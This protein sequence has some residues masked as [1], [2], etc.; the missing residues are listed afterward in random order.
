VGHRGSYPSSGLLHGCISRPEV[1]YVSDSAMTF[2][3]SIRKATGSSGILVSNDR[4]IEAGVLVCRLNRN[5]LKAA[6]L[7]NQRAKA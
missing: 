1:F 7:A 2:S 6:V 3:R 5:G 4:P